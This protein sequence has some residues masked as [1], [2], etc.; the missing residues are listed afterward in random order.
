MLRTRVV[1]ACLILLLGIGPMIGI[2]SVSAQDERPNIVIG[3]NAVPNDLCV[4]C[5]STFQR[6]I[7]YN[8]FDPLIGRDFGEDGWGTDPI[9]GIAKSWN[10]VSDT[11]LDL[12]IRQGVLFHNG[13]ELTAEDVAFTLSSEKLWGPDAL[14]PDPLAIGVFKNVEVLDEHTVRITT[15]F[16]DPALISRLQ[17]HIARVVPKDYFLEVGVDAFRQKPIGTGPYRVESYQ[18][19]D[20]V[21]LVAFDDYWGGK[22]PVA[23]ITYRDIPE[24]STRI[25]AL[26]AGEVDLI[27]GVLPQQFGLLES[28]GFKVTVMPQENIQMFSFMTGPEELPVHDARIRRALIL[29]ADLDT[30]AE[31]LFNGTVEPL[32]GIQSPAYGPYYEKLPSEYDPDMARQLVA[33][34][35]Y[36]GAPIKLQFISN[37]FVLVNETALLLQEMWA[38]VGL[39]VKLDIIPDFTLHTLN[40]PTDVSMWSTSNNISI[41]DPVNPVCTTYTSNTYYASSNRIAISETLDDLCQQLT[42]TTDFNT[43]MEIWRA[44]QAEWE[45]NP[46]AL[47]LW[48]RPE[49]YAQRADLDWQPLPDFS[50]AFGPEFFPAGR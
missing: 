45:A 34:S 32:V 47:F 19:R 36:D 49:F 27:V 16:P 3:L 29:S 24:S 37:N 25:A 1:F 13:Q 12:T 35:G 44:I 2:S 10:W 11:E 6:Q 22:P 18:A 14:T 28:K 20:E 4:T 23:S 33:E 7:V 17:S 9:P 39:K 43:R 26:L 30:I 8:V 38:K 15:V 50:M 48:Q 46:Q 21:R 31:Q 5:N 40:P 42:E 41:A